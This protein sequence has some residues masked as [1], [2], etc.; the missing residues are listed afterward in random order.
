MES[1]D[2]Y[3]YKITNPRGFSYVGST[4]NLKDRFY[5]YK[6]LRVTSQ[7]KIYNSL[8]K[9]GSENHE[10]TVLYKCK[11][12]CRNVFESFFGN[13]Y[14]CISEKG[15]NLALPKISD[16]VLHT[17]KY[18]RDKIGKAHKGKKISDEQKRNISERSKEWHAN[19]THPMKNKIPWNKGKPFLKG[20]KNPMYGVKRS[21]EWKN[22]ASERAKLSSKKG[23]LHYRSKCIID[24][25]S[26]VFYE[27]V[28]EASEYSIY[29][30]STLK[31]HVRDGNLSTGLL[32]CSFL[33]KIMNKI[34]DKENE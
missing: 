5:R 14:N 18:T 19:N 21:A 7:V 10:F 8:V 2:V 33:E 17:S 4:V 20:D 25:N 34:K 12:C 22:I 30:Y 9:Y 16:S 15:L 26:G 29:A 1:R 6:T 32:D 3:I 13:K 31:R 24:I 27:N 28:R 11:E 23:H